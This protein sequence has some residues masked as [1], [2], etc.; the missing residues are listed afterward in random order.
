MGWSVNGAA[1][2]QAA[3][4]RLRHIA[5]EL[6]IEAPRIAVISGD[7]L[8]DARGQELLRSHLAPE[9]AERAIDSGA[10]AGFVGLH[11]VLPQGRQDAMDRFDVLDGDPCR[12]AVDPGSL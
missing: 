8:S 4:Q 10:L 1:N 3:A 11:E 7:D 2:P 9:D 5:H 12:N 6:G